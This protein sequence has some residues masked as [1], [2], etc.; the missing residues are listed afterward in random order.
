GEVLAPFGIGHHVAGFMRGSHTGPLMPVRAETIMSYFDGPPGVSCLAFSVRNGC[1][2]EPVDLFD[3]PYWDWIRQR[4][5]RKAS[6]MR[7][8]GFSGPAM[9]P[10]P[11]LEYGGI[12]HRMEALETRFAVST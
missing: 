10:Y 8:Q 9:L 1:L 5:S 12:K 2:S 4:V 3:H 11:D 6:E 7:A